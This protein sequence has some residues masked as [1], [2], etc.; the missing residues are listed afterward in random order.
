[1]FLFSTCWVRI[2]TQLYDHSTR[3]PFI[4]AKIQLLEVILVHDDKFDIC[5][6]LISSILR[7]R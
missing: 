2:A 1:M 4:K 7:K 6:L 3:T 5:E